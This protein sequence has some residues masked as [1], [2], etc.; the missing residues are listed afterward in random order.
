MRRAGEKCDWEFLDLH[1]QTQLIWS[2]VIQTLFL[3]SFL[4]VGCFGQLGLPE[5]RKGLP[6]SIMVV[7]Q[8]L[9]LFVEVRTL[10]GQLRR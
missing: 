4:M 8:I 10:V 5:K 7:Q 3:Q 6:D 2:V 9:V 1:R